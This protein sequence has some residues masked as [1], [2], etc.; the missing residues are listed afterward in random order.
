[1]RRGLGILLAVAVLVASTATLWAQNGVCPDDTEQI[2]IMPGA[3]PGA[4]AMC[5]EG[6]GV[7]TFWDG[8]ESPCGGGVEMRRAFVGEQPGLVV[9]FPAGQAF[10]SGQ[11]LVS[12]YAH[13][14]D[15]LGKPVASQHGFVIRSFDSARQQIGAQ[16]AHTGS[17]QLIIG[18]KPYWR[19][20]RNPLTPIVLPAAQ[21]GYLHISADSIPALASAFNLFSL[22]VWDAAGT[23]PALCDA[24][25][26]LP[27]P[28]P[29]QTPIP[30]ETPIGAPTATP[31][32]TPSSVPTMPQGYPTATPPTQTPT[33]NPS[34]T[35][36][37]FNTLPPLH[38][39]TLIPG[40]DM[41]GL[42]IPGLDLPD[43]G[44]VEEEVSLTVGLTPNATTEARINGVATQ[45]AVGGEIATR[46]YTTTQESL[47]WLST[48][49][50]ATTGISSPVDIATAMTG[51]LT[52]P[53][54]YVKAMQLYLPH[55]WP[56]ILFLFLVTIWMFFILIVKFAIAVIAD[57][58][59]VL[60]RIIELFPG[61]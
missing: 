37:P 10:P 13:A 21:G 50:T 23:S 4:M 35:P 19:Y 14:L 33:P 57:S 8:P 53:I 52:T 38:T 5:A 27:T 1:M 43:L 15:I 12:F 42:I 29:S 49:S 11:V 51:S 47:S 39:P 6:N 44:G 24:P 48:D 28:T 58:S 56:M 25:G 18:N 30:T 9:V 41:P 61:M 59:D 54:S 40:S 2:P 22:R 16:V 60:R 34:A 20:P 17:A 46:W 26:A 36:R 7:A 55:L 45:M 32:A 31:S 3:W